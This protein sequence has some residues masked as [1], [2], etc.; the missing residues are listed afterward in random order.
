[1][2]HPL[3]SSVPPP[4]R[5]SPAEWF[6]R[7]ASDWEWRGVLVFGLVLTVIATVGLITFLYSGAAEQANVPV[8]GDKTIFVP[9]TGI[10]GFN[11]E[12][13]CQDPLTK[14]K[15]LP[16]P[17]AGVTYQLTRV[18]DNVSETVL[19]VLSPSGDVNTEF[20]RHFYDTT[21]G[22]Q[23]EPAFVTD[24]ALDCIRKKAG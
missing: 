12:V 19:V 13:F 3:P 22:Q 23:P 8:P 20:S 21:V 9:A 18:R 5:L 24:K 16:A 14:V 10:D 7:H 4:R 15:P 11:T 17:D 2:N 6:R 1:M